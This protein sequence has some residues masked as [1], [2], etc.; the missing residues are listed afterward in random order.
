MLKKALLPLTLATLII[1][2]LAGSVKAE[3]ITDVTCVPDPIPYPGG[4]TTITVFA[5]KAGVG[6]ITVTQPNG[7]RSWAFILIPHGGESDSKIYPDD[8]HR[9]DP[10][11]TMQVGEYKVRVDLLGFIYWDTFRVSFFVVPES[12][13]G[14]IMATTAS[15]TASIGL[16][17]IKRL[18]TKH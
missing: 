13:L 4:K 17:A 14:T 15:L 8:F 12:P 5:D 9:G 16:V 11:S 18:R 2:L 10:A 6:I 7:E 1:F 3:E